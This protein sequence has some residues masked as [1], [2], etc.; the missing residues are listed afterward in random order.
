[1]HIIYGRCA[2]AVNT[3][4]FYWNVGYLR[5]AFDFDVDGQR[6]ILDVI[7][8]VCVSVMYLI[9]SSLLDVLLLDIEEGLVF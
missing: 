4:Y 6:L 1:M 3:N 9:L 7:I 5:N 2:I 8:E